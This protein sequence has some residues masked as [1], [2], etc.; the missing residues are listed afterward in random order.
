MGHPVY[1]RCIW[2]TAQASNII[3]QKVKHLHIV[4][5]SLLWIFTR[6]AILPNV[7]KFPIWNDVALGFLKVS[8]QR[9]EE[10]QEQEDD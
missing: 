5:V 1:I 4:D 3:S 7:A 2:S 6:K 10:K 8:R 9:E